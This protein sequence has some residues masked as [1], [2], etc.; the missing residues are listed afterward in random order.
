MSSL[1]FFSSLGVFLV[2]NFF[3]AELCARLSAEVRDAAGVS[4]TIYKG[5]QTFAVD[6]ERRRA[7]LRRVGEGARLLVEGRLMG[8]KPALEAHFKTELHGIQGPDFLTYKPGDFFLAHRD[9]NADPDAPGVM[10][11]RRVS[12]VIFLN[13][14]SDGPDAACYSGGA[15]TLF[16]LIDAPVWESKG[17]PLRGKEGLLVAFRSELIHEVEPVTRGER[18]TIVSWFF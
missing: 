9:G 3:D 16:G 11:A 6:E 15:L 13:G 1:N 2:K 18:H 5:D 4:T 8:V 10:K 17:F 14:E 12:V 7:K